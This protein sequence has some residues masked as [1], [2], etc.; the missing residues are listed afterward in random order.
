MFSQKGKNSERLNTNE[1]QQFKETAGFK[2]FM[3]GTLNQQEFQNNASQKNQINNRNSLYPYSESGNDLL[4]YSQSNILASKLNQQPMTTPR[5]LEILTNNNSI[6]R[7]SSVL[8]MS[9]LHYKPFA[10]RRCLEKLNL[11]M[12]ENINIDQIE[13]TQD[14]NSAQK[15]LKNIAFAEFDVKTVENMGYENFNKIFRLWQQAILNYGVQQQ[16]EQAKGEKLY[17][18][19]REHLDASQKIDDIKKAHA[20]KKTKLYEQIKTLQ[21]QINELKQQSQKQGKF[22]CTYC[23]KLF[24]N[25]EDIK[26]HI[27]SAH[28]DKIEKIKEDQKVIEDFGNPMRL[29]TRREERHLQEQNELLAQKVAKEVE[30]KMQQ[31]LKILFEKNQEL[32]KRKREEEQRNVFNTSTNDELQENQ[33]HLLSSISKMNS[34]F[35]GFEEMFAQMQT[36]QQNLIEEQQQQNKRLKEIESDQKKLENERF[37]KEREYQEY[38]KSMHNTQTKQ[39]ELTASRNEE[40]YYGSQLRPEELQLSKEPSFGNPYMNQF[41]GQQRNSSYMQNNQKKKDDFFLELVEEDENKENFFMDRNSRNP[42]EQYYNTQQSHQ[43]NSQ[44]QMS[45]HMTQNESST[46]KRDLKRQFKEKYKSEDEVVTQQSVIKKKNKLMHIGDLESD[47][48]SDLLEES[49]E[50]GVLQPTNKHEIFKQA[51][52]Q[53]K[54]KLMTAQE[55]YEIEKDRQYKQ[56]AARRDL[57]DENRKKKYNYPFETNKIINNFSSLEQDKIRNERLIDEVMQMNKLKEER[58]QSLLQSDYEI[59]LVNDQVDIEE[60][61]KHFIK[62]NLNFEFDAGSDKNEIEDLDQMKFD[63]LR[64]AYQQK[65]NPKQIN[66]F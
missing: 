61:K 6:L 52:I 41:R 12:L 58:N 49:Y 4:Q 57:I 60:M 3:K 65:Y 54:E 10:Y 23:T 28:K 66:R 11:N 9:K 35:G 32:Q 64:L 43:T 62:N 51:E 36:K 34:V 21:W 59:E 50:E 46:S 63:Q 44:I 38:L 2:P 26:T 24:E 29:M 27:R 18:K 16:E 42:L 22:K 14:L 13:Y 56:A 19:Y 40:E 45:Q 53:F 48:D 17:T 30:E 33:K 1:S 20:D 8:F 5:R 7:E 31:Q 55:K 37:A 25:K 39:L 47:Y 15:M